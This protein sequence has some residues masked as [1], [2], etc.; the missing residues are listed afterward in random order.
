MNLE[1]SLEHKETWKTIF[2]F[3]A[4]V[5]SLSS[6]FHYAIVHLY[7]SRIYIGGLMWCPAAAAIITL[8]LKK[9]AISS[10]NWNWGSWKY[11]WLLCVR[12]FSS[13]IKQFY[14]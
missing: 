13:I 6:L 8:K 4:I 5:T 9:R 1:N 14:M 3:L 11:I 2:V 10:L 7:P 12:L